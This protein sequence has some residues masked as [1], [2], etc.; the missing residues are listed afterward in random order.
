MGVFQYRNG[1]LCC[2]AAPLDRIAAAVGTPFFVYSRRRL[3]ANWNAAEKP[4]AAT[5]HLTCFAVKA[6]GNP[7]IIRLF[8]ERGAGADIVSGGELRLAL[9]AG[10]PPERVLFSGVGKTDAEIEQ[11]VSAGVFALNVESFDELSV[12]SRIA[13]RIR[14]KARISIRVNPKVDPKTHPY[15]ATGLR[16]SKFGIP[17]ERAVEAF[18]LAASMPGISVAGVHCHI[19]SQ[20]LESAPYSEAAA[21]IV[22]L[23]RDL[24]S[25]RMKLEFVDLGGGWGIDYQRIVETGVEPNPGRPLPTGPGRLFESILP[26]LAGTGARLLVEPGRF[27]VGDAGTLVTEVTFIK[28]NGGRRFVIVDAGMNDLIR[29]SLYDAYHQIVP[30]RLKRNRPVGRVDVVGPI[31]ESG[32]FFAHDRPLPSVRRG[33]LLAITGAGAY[34]Y[35]LSSNYNGRPRAAEVL[36]SGSGFRTI[37]QREPV[38]VLWKGTGLEEKKLAN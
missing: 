3:I 15:I 26:D 24:R 13:A 7:H 8:A 37:R 19:G 11:A 22:R 2:E 5:P 16:E 38:D 18:R 36:V 35:S 9:L 12:V 27:L 21:F 32:D 25:E 31:C 34:G 29:P 23:V 20:I 4:L 1:V 28:E 10:V 6:N 17:A 33:E 14:K 30:V